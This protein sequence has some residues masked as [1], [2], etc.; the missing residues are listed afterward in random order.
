MLPLTVAPTTLVP[1]RQGLF[2]RLLGYLVD[3]KRRFGVMAV[4][5]VAMYVAQ[6]RG[7][8]KSLLSYAFKR[9]EQRMLAQMEDSNKEMTRQA[10]KSG[11]FTRALK[12]Y[13]DRNAALF[14]PA[15]DKHFQGR[16]ELDRIKTQLRDKTLT[17]AEKTKNWVAFKSAVLKSTV[18]VLVAK[19][20]LS[21]VWLVREA[22]LAKCKLSVEQ[23]VKENK[24][25]ETKFL[26]DS[27]ESAKEFVSNF[28]DATIQ[29]LLQ[30]FIPIIEEMAG[31]LEWRLT[32]KVSIDAFVAKLQDI[33]VQLLAPKQPTRQREPDFIDLNF[34]PG[35]LSRTVANCRLMHKKF[36][37]Q[38]FKFRDFGKL[39]YNTLFGNV[40]KIA[41]RLEHT[42]YSENL[43]S[44]L[45]AY[46]LNTNRSAVVNH[47]LQETQR[48]S[49]D[50]LSTIAE[51]D[52][53]V[54]DNSELVSDHDHRR[55]QVDYEDRQLWEGRD[56]ERQHAIIVQLETAT[57]NC[58]GDFLDTLSNPNAQLLSEASL[59]FQFKKIANRLAL[60]K[61]AAVENQ[62]DIPFMRLLT[63][64][65]KIVEEEFLSRDA[66]KND[67]ALY[68]TRSKE[69]FSLAKRKAGESLGNTELVNL[70][71]EI[72]EEAKVHGILQR[73][74]REFGAR[75]FFDE[76]FQ[77]FYGDEFDSPN[78][79]KN[80]P[81]KNEQMELM[82][83]LGRIKPPVDGQMQLPLD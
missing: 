4:L 80:S 34:K 73:A 39:I 9:V 11:D 13:T 46:R 57:Y 71:I 15:M 74:A 37:K 50:K 52:E 55:G 47:L 62:G 78:N 1:P 3:R 83:M 36:V 48:R 76:E 41:V 72:A 65:H 60:L 23:I 20:F 6:R 30:D 24:S 38:S 66:G 69:L 51:I 43:L 68:E 77:L 16:Y 2:N 45:A 44:R 14:S 27:V 5:L 64:I 54:E 58:L 61:N 75:L 17:T 63:S 22:I 8:L 32:D 70:N 79:E 49:T 35:S 53:K 42:L 10:Q 28:I 82:Q 12:E 59:E 40:S 19:S 25:K 26:G 33:S 7:Y 21:T 81:A 29:L 31:G 67:M 56:Y 18:L